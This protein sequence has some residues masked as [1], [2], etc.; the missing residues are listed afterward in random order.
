MTID[1][2]RKFIK[3]PEGQD[4]PLR[5]GSYSKFVVIVA[6]ELPKSVVEVLSL[7]PKHTLRDKINEV[8]FL[9]E[10]NNLV[11]ELFENNKVGDKICEIE[12]SG[13]WYANRRTNDFLAARFGKNCEVYLTKDA[14]YRNKLKDKFNSVQ[15]EKN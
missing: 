10:V 1:N 4:R 8:H 13:K 9:A 12:A 3:V 6:A 7:G 11:F 5:N 2:R 15:L 14:M